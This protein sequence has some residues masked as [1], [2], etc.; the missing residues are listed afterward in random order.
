MYNKFSNGMIEVITGPMFSGKSEELLRR[1]R[2]LEYAKYNILVIKPSFDTRFSISK[3][4]SRAG[5]EHKTFV[6]DD[7]KKVYELINEDTNAIVIDEAHFFGDDIVQV[8]N[9][10]A[11]KGF[12]VIVSGLDQDFL[13]RPFYNMSQ[14]LSLAERVTK[15]QAVCVVCHNLAS[16]SYRKSNDADVLLLDNT[17]NYEARCRKCHN[18][19]IK[20]KDKK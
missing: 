17:S 20:N 1:I 16:C 10:L 12:L 7:I 6:L 4:V 18:D 14:I 5:T 15:L 11:N 3:I 8:V 2:I 9:E 19:G 13:K